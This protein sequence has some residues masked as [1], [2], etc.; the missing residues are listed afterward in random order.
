MQ[1]A[2]VHQILPD[3]LPCV[4]LEQ[5]IVRKNNSRPC[6]TRRAKRAVDMLQEVELLV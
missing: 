3:F 2:F 4:V 1:I 5:N 6:R